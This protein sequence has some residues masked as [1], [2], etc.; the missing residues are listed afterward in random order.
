MYLITSSKADRCYHFSVAA[1][2]RTGGSLPSVNTI[3]AGVRWPADLGASPRDARLFMIADKRWKFMHVEGGFRPILFDLENDPD[4]FQD[5]GASEAH[6]D[7]IELMYQRLGQWARRMSQ[8][9]TKFEQDLLQA[10][11][12]KAGAVGVL[13]G[14]YDENDV[15]AEFTSKY[16]GRVAQDYTKHN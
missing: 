8:R 5:L 9:T 6:T 14:V 7:I 12:R 1:S 2:Q 16:R 4:E 15:P 3:M 10:R 13:I 11:Q